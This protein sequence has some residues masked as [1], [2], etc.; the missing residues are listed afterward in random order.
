V[1]AGDYDAIV[2][3]GGSGYKVDDP[4]GQRI[5]QEA[6]AEGKVVA[7]ICVAPISLAKA[8]VVEGKR[9]TAS[10]Q[11]NV[12]EKAGATVVTDGSVVRDGLIITANGPGGARKFG[13]AIAAALR[14]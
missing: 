3:V 13:E 11:W 5:A 9:V 14:E 6:V 8:G 7:A 10:T 12:L 4:E 1:R 2:F